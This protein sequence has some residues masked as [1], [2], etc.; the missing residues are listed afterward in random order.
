MKRSCPVCP[1]CFRKVQPTRHRNIQ[2]HMDSIG[3]AT[4]PFGGEPYELALAGDVSP[5]RYAA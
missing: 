4:C 2:G 1:V 3:R 5:R